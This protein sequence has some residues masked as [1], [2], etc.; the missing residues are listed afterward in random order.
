MVLST[1]TGH[2]GHLSSGW[3]RKEGSGVT[4]EWE[5]EVIEEPREKGRGGLSKKKRGL[6]VAKKK[7]TTFDA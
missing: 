1:F 2:C 7:S 6:M 5:W 4:A 3:S